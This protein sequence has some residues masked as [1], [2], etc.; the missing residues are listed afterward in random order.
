MILFFAHVDAILIL[1]PGQM[2]PGS[3]FILKKMGVICRI[4][5]LSLHFSTFNFQLSTLNC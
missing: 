1:Q 5:G 2:D 3:F 4:Y